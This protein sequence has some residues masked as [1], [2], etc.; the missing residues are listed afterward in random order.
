MFFVRPDKIPG[1]DSKSDCRWRFEPTPGKQVPALWFAGGLF[2][3]LS[4]G[5]HGLRGRSWLRLPEIRISFHPLIPR[6]AHRRVELEQVGLGKLNRRPL[7]LAELLH[8]IS[9]HRGHERLALL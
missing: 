3:C 9:A 8:A 7:Q 6:I 4:F 2:F 1:A 5:L